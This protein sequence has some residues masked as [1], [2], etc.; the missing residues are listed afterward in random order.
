MICSKD[1]IKKHRA[2][3]RFLSCRR[4]GGERE[5]IIL[6]DPVVLTGGFQHDLVTTPQN[7][8]SVTIVVSIY[9]CDDDSTLKYHSR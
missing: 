6:R 5:A 4:G 9:G 7:D 1:T 3:V 2:A 8:R